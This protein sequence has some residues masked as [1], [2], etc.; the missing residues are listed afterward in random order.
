MVGRIEKQSSGGLYHL[1]CFLLY[2]AAIIG[3]KNGS[4]RGESLF[5]P[6]SGKVNDATN[7]AC[8]RQIND[9]ISARA[10]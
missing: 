1:D 8:W 7:Y 4:T 2:R 6:T 10:T 5:S 9:S 3:N